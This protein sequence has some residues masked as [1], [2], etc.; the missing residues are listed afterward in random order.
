[1]HFKTNY[2]L[3]KKLYVSYLLFAAKPKYL[4]F[5]ISITIYESILKNIKHNKYK[6]KT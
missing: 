4:T 3:K 1:M 2:K 5:N 6:I